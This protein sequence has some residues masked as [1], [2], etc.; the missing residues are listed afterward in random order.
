MDIREAIKNRHSVRQYKDMPIE[1]EHRDKLE[2][3]AKEYNDLWLR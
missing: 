1:Q 3:L 2:A